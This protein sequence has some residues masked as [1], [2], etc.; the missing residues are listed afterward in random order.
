M[1]I[2]KIPLDQ[3]AILNVL[4]YKD[5]VLVWKNKTG[6]LARL[7]GKTAGYAHHTG[8]RYIKLGTQP[9]AAHRVVWVYH[10]GMIDETMQIDHINGIKSDNRIENLRLVTA[11]ENCFNRSKHNAKGYSW[12]KSVKKWQSYI[13]INGKPKYLGVFAKEQ[14]AR[15]AYLDSCKIYHKEFSI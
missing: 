4:E 11:Q 14:D 15:N 3:T 5:G 9:I 2:N 8:Y 6:N 10:N 7:N 12:N 13:S 1:K